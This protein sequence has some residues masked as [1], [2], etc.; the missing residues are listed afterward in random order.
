M[1]IRTESLNDYLRRYQITLIILLI[2]TLVMLFVWF[3]LNGIENP[4]VVYQ[5]GGL[6][7]ENVLGGDYW[8]LLT[9]AFLHFGIYHYLFNMLFLMVLGP[10]LEIILGKIK[11]IVFIFISII[12]T[13]I[14]VIIVSEQPG[15]G[16]SGIVFAIM[17]Y[18]IFLAGRKDKS[19]SSFDS[20]LIIQ[21]TLFS[22][23]GTIIFSVVTEQMV[24]VS[25]HLGG[26]ISGI[27]LSFFRTTFKQNNLV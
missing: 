21:V 11:F 6:I 3:C 4:Y 20:K 17:G 10:P 13:S 7:N 12:C 9:Y 19:L 25:G 16:A 24:T 5:L 26:F 23:I 8:R 22:W 2:N 15:V 18:F 14:L 1:F 27:I